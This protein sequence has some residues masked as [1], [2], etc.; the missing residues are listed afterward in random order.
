MIGL[1]KLRTYKHRLKNSKNFCHLTAQVQSWLEHNPL[2]YLN[3]APASE[4]GPADYLWFR[5]S[6]N[7]VLGSSMVKNTFCLGRAHFI[8]SSMVKRYL[9][10]VEHGR[11]HFFDWARSKLILLGS[12]TVDHIFFWSSMVEFLL[13]FG[14]DGRN[15]PT[16]GRDDRNIKIALRAGFLIVKWIK[17]GSY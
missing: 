5:Y 10:W 13:N 17:V 11:A 1:K 12:S 14:L 7:I 8:R 2:E 9:A 4:K 16:F 6:K 15:I 3:I